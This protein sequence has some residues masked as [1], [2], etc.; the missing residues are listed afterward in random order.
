[1]P[2]SQAWLFIFF[3]V[4]KI[5]FISRWAEILEILI[6]RMMCR[7]PPH[8]GLNTQSTQG[9]RQVH[10]GVRG[11][12]LHLPLLVQPHMCQAVTSNMALSSK[13]GSKP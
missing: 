4:K 6:V 10:A 11:G 5:H 3:K 8:V 1:M 9:Y 13:K 7:R 2:L 12:R